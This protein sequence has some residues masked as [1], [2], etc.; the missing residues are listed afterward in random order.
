MLYA[1][2]DAAEERFFDEAFLE[3]L[4]A[5]AGS[6]GPLSAGVGD[7]ALHERLA[8]FLS[9]GGGALGE[10][11][12]VALEGSALAERTNRLLE[13]ARGGRSLAAV[14]AVENFVVFFQALV[15]TLAGDG[16][17]Q[18]RRFFF[19]LVPTLLQVAA[20]DA[21]GGGSR[22]ADARAA[23]HNLETILIEISDVRLAPSEGE[24]VFR[25][26][27][28]L[29]GF[30]AAGEY[31]MANRIVSAQLLELIERNKLARALY[32]LMEAEVGIQRYLKERLGYTTPR[33][34]V[35]EDAAALADYGPLRVLEEEAIGEASR[36]VQV[37]VPGLARLSDVVLQLVREDG[38]SHALRLDSL[39]SAE[40]A[41]PAGLYSLGL[42]YDPVVRRR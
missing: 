8:E 25:S 24:L 20:Q 23:L 28:Q 15:P 1:V 12:F 6:R 37:H 31:E 33:L 29:A 5:I 19:R 7:E 21:A 22:L 3:E 35:P 27:D 17:R 11:D 40:L 26:I 39:G 32:R 18:V 2:A 10:D 16:A 14:Q 34:R 30:I 4:E 42:S 41:V 13:I 36:L 9:E 38:A